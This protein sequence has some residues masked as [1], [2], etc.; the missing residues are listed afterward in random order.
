[1]KTLVGIAIVS[2]V[3]FL[4]CEMDEAT[5]KATLGESLFFDKNI[6]LTRETSCATCHDPEH[7]FVDA[8]F[9]EEGTD[10]SIFIDGAFSVGDDGVTLGG[11]NSPTAMYA[12]YSPK[13]GDNDGAYKG[14]QFHDG[15]AATLKV[16]AMGPPLDQAEMMMPDTESVS[17]RLQENQTYVVGL[18]ALFGDDVFD[19]P[20]KAF[21]SMAECIAEFEKT[22]EFA[23]FDSKYDRWLEGTYEFTALEAE[24]HKAYFNSESKNCVFCHTLNSETEA[25]TKELFTNYR[26]ENIGTPRNI[27]AMDARAALGLQD[28]NATYA[29]LGGTVDKAEH[30]GKGKVP[31]L[32]N[33]AVTAPYMNNGVFKKLRTVLEFYDHMAGKGGHP[34]NPETGEAWVAN[35]HNETINYELLQKTAPFTDN[36]IY[37]IEAF[38]RTLTD[39]K[40]EDL[41]EPLEP[42][43]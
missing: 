3:S 17:E 26:Y 6:S 41:L 29:G 42:A 9:L 35:D 32:R 38:L 25:D 24:G 40:Y 43:N 22:E 31:T 37:A 36:K 28:T 15:R 11:R 27:A 5:N 18:K 39:K 19:D 33:I 7:A 2:M 34:I 30:L 12:K 8:R 21:D 16:Q 4:G 1:M 13:F 14:G 23:P 20:D 10:Q